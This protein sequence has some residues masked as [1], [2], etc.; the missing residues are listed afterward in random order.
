MKVSNLNK[1]W[2]KYVELG[3]LDAAYDCFYAGDTFYRCTRKLPLRFIISK[4]GYSIIRRRLKSSSISF[5]DTEVDLSREFV[6]FW[7]EPNLVG[8]YL[9][10]AIFKSVYFNKII[11]IRALAWFAHWLCFQGEIFKAAKIF[12]FIHSQVIQ[13][14]EGKRLHGEVLSLLACYTFS[15]GNFGWGKDYYEKAHLTLSANNDPFFVIF[16]IGTWSRVPFYFADIGYMDEILSL[17][18]EVNP[19]ES[20]ERYGLRVL[21]YCAYLK[22][23]NGDIGEGKVFLQSAR[24][25]FERSGSHLDRSVFLLTET[26]IAILHNDL[27]GT[28]QLISEARVELSKFGKYKYYELLIDVFDSYVNGDVKRY[29]ALI[30]K[31][32]GYKNVD[33]IIQ[34]LSKH[35]G[36]VLGLN[37]DE[38]DNWYKDFFENSLLSFSDIEEMTPENLESVVKSIAHSKKVDFTIQPGNELVPYLNIEKISGYNL[39]EFSLF[40]NNKNYIIKTSSPFQKWRNPKVTEAIESS[41]RTLQQ[42]CWNTKLLKESSERKQ[43]IELGRLARTTAHDLRSPL[44]SLNITIKSLEIESE[45][46]RVAVLSSLG[47]IGDIA[48]NLISITKNPDNK[49]NN[50]LNDYLV[51]GLIDSVISAKRIEYINLKNIE[52]STSFDDS[53]Y[54]AFTRLNENDF[55]SVLSNIINNSVEAIGSKKGNV[56]VRTRVEK[57]VLSI[58][59]TDNGKGAGKSVIERVFDED[60]SV[61]KDNGSGIGLF[62]AKRVIEAIGGNIAIESQERIGT[63][64]T[65]KLKLVDIP[66]WFPQKITLSGYEQVV[67]LDDDPSIHQVWNSKIDKLI[68][69]INIH[70]ARDFEEHINE[71]KK[72]KTLFL[73]DSELYGEEKNG[74][75]L[76]RDYHLEKSSI[77]V[78]GKFED[79]VIL[80]QVKNMKIK[81]LPKTLLHQIPIE[82]DKK[83]N[84]IIVEDDDILRNIF[85]EKLKE[86]FDTVTFREFSS[87]EMLLN[88]NNLL[89]DDTIVIS[90]FKFMDNQM[91][92]LDLFEKLKKENASVTHCLISGYERED[93]IDERTSELIDAF[94]PKELS[95]IENYLYERLN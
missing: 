69:I 30:T 38:A 42:L 35:K 14:N 52:I 76:I 82:F 51:N 59:I 77:L 70:S 88:K 5:D 61:G 15:R 43:T 50:K 41:L 19:F 44:E 63:T 85:T 2:V 48:N 83:K 37:I 8:R 58:E 57:E 54:S 23:L 84:V 74:Q 66:S 72:R 45:K 94:L 55:K 13:R 20:D 78:T 53:S 47:R 60:F 46:E 79:E 33:A 32:K 7:K 95:Q 91:T 10:T 29:N 39:Y 81:L 26:L 86:R 56:E 12:R 11:P 18:D 25:C 1:P 65:I 89:R 49:I 36:R 67:V 3:Q 31:N 80:S 4:I 87:P 68:K 28:R 16:N 6:L 34:S 71:L 92:G 93:L 62:N 73:I 64:V 27:L 21:I 22:F 9:F 40:F 90:D 24:R 17:Y 75:Q